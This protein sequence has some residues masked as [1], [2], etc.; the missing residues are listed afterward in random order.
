[1]E[2]D[3]DCFP[4]PDSCQLLSLEPGESRSMVYGVD[5]KTYTV[6]VIKIKRVVSSKPPR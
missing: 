5:S 6:K 2:G 3:G 4:S 1:M